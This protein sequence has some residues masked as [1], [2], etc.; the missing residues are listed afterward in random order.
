MSAA[1]DALCQCHPATPFGLTCTTHRTVVER[2]ENLVR[3]VMT[4]ELLHDA[5]LGLDEAGLLKHTSG[6]ASVREP[7]I[8]RCGRQRDWKPVR[9][10][11]AQDNA[12]AFTRP[13]SGPDCEGQYPSASENTKG[14]QKGTFRMR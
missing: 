10:D 11:G 13:W 5:C 6:L 14:L 3:R 2:I 1:A 4:P 9:L 12:E 8:G 7:K